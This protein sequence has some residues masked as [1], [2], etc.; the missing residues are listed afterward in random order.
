MSGDMEREE[1]E[2]ETKGNQS[3][4]GDAQTETESLSKSRINS[5]DMFCAVIAGAI[6]DFRHPGQR[7]SIR[8]RKEGRKGEKGKGI[9]LMSMG[10][11]FI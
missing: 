10:L 2:Q 1:Q 8:V 5:L 4:S 6:H 9:H 3:P 7:N 11:V